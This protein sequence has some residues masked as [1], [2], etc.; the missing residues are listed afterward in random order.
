MVTGGGS[1]I[2]LACARALAADGAEVTVLGRRAEPLQRA[3]AEGAAH[4]C[5]V[6]DA[7]DEETIVAAG[8]FGIVVHAAGAAESAPFAATDRALVERMLA[9][10]LLTAFAVARAVLPPMLAARQGRIV[11]VASTAA[12]KGYPY[13]SA[14]VAAKHAVL[15]LARAL[16]VEVAGSGVT[17]NAICPGFTDT[18][19]LAASIERIVVAT[20]KTA[21]EVRRSFV[22]YNPQKRL[23]RPEEVAAA[24]LWLCSE[25]A[26]AVNGK[27]IAIDGGET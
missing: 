8:P 1:G 7:Q 15:G 21:D 19:L 12:L 6:A 24:V 23:V 5:L 18:P 11:F 4:A 14:Y 2:G 27:A 3:V 17:A 20:G 10:N 26:S 22:S 13:V 9:A 16:A 25:E